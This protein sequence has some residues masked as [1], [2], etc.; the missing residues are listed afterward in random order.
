[1]PLTTR[2]KR[3][4]QR[5][6]DSFRDDRLFIVASDDTYAP[7]QYFDGFKIPRIRFLVI[8]TLDGT[9]AARHVLSRLEGFE[10]SE[11]D[12][13]WMILDTDHYIKEAHAEGFLDAI[14]EAKRMGINVALSRPSFEFWLLLHHIDNIGK[15]SEIVDA[16][17]AAE[18]LRGI[19]GEYNKTSINLDKF[20][21]GGVC[22]ACELGRKI[23]KEV[24]GGNRPERPTS[25][26]Y[27]LWEALVSKA[28]MSQLPREL[29]PLA[30]AVR[31]RRG[32]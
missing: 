3:P 29:L 1:V 16:K 30:H 31:A 4:L 15:T 10:I 32:E 11:D 8:P 12:E 9:S 28:S 26:V 24:G 6:S 25:R 27:L 17:S 2:K 19:L 5:D 21:L 13:R 23:D 14:R 7:K 20:S 22:Q 18:H